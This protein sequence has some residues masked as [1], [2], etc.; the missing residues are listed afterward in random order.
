MSL[1]QFQINNKKYF[2]LSIV[3]IIIMVIAILEYAPRYEDN[4]KGLVTKYGANTRLA[5]NS[6][7]INAAIADNDKVIIPEG[8]FSIQSTVILKNGLTFQGTRGS[9][10]IVI[11]D[12]FNK[13]PYLPENEF[14]IINQDFSKTYS[15][16]TADDITIRGITFIMS[17]NANDSIA[18]IL[19]LA[20]IKNLVIE[21]CDFIIES[22]LISG[23]NLDLYAGCKNVKITDNFFKNDTG[24]EAG[25]EIMVR[26]L[27]ANGAV[28]DNETTNVLIE[29]NRFD[30]NGNDEVIAVWGC[31]GKVSN[32]TVR[33]NEIY[34]YGRVPDVIISAF[35][36]E[37]NAYSTA[38]AEYIVFDSNHITTDS[39]VGTVFQI[40]Q[41]TDSISVLDN[42]KII[43]NTIEAQVTTTG[44]SNIIK[45]INQPNYMNITIKSN[46]ITNT[47]RVSIDYGING[48]G[49]ISNNV[50][51]GLFN[52]RIANGD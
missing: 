26:C 41:K 4:A 45:S 46:T 25:C 30:K 29:N 3:V 48:K 6:I 49:A 8:S 13:G 22:D 39:I 44:V 7:A 42:V 16:T 36:G 18:T 33:N 40:G 2:I 11:N 17:E 35:A 21:D 47:G 19:G 28:I 32:V 34:T 52:N 37:D 51:T 24:A 14:A 20:N 23:N 38:K 5:D 27:T 43:N 10:K 9:S 1:A 31:V 50:I 12:T 15:D